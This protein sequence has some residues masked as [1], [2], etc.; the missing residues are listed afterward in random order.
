[1][2]NKNIG[3]YLKDTTKKYIDNF[4]IL[5]KKP[6]R[7]GFEIKTNVKTDYLIYTVTE[8]FSNNDKKTIINISQYFNQSEKKL[9]YSDSFNLPEQFIDETP[10]VDNGK[11]ISFLNSRNEH[12]QKLSKSNITKI[13]L[14]EI[15]FNKFARVLD[16]DFYKE[17]KKEYDFR[18]DAK[19]YN[20]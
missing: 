7:I 18:Q 20:I 13:E 1:M 10:N 6:Q 16:E 9:F 4:K 19:K 15:L 3:P 12:V 2:M 11:E 14:F 5:L 17:W 8:F